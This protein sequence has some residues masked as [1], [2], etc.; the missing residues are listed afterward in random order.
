MW[1]AHLQLQ[2]MGSR[3]RR[4]RNSKLSLATLVSLRLTW[5]TRDPALKQNNT[6][7]ICTIH[8]HNTKKM[9]QRVEWCQDGTLGKDAC[10]QAW[11][12]EFNSP[13]PTWRKINPQSCL[14]RVHLPNPTAQTNEYI[15]SKTPGEVCYPDLRSCPLSSLLPRGFCRAHL[16]PATH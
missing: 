11:R 12:P 2:N 15:V 3:S 14:E 8:L 5:A 4:V 6:N 9:G 10:C 16:G 7:G 1:Y 13:R